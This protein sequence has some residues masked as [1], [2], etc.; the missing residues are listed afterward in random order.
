MSNFGRNK[1]RWYSSYGR[2][3]F[4]KGDFVT[5][6][7][8]RY[9]YSGKQH[10]W[11][12]GEYREV[13]DVIQNLNQDWVLVIENPVCARTSEYTPKNFIKR[14]GVTHVTAGFARTQYFAVK[15]NL[16]QAPEQS[17]ISDN[18]G[19]WLSDV[20][21]DH[22][23]DVNHYDTTPLR[24]SR[25]EVLSEIKERIEAGESWVICQTL[26][27]VQGEPPRPPIRVTELR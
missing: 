26:A 25:Q 6:A 14:E 24:L 4:S 16:G 7:P 1:S 3:P 13:L 5:P 17:G 18:G 22:E 21:K 10:M 23:T 8:G 27:L 12:V 2:P 11:R 9:A 20:N 15:L 19:L